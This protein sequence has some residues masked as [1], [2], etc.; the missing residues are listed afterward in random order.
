MRFSMMAV[1]AN[2]MIDACKNFI[3]DSLECIE[4]MSGMGCPDGCIQEACRILINHAVNLYVCGLIGEEFLRMLLEGIIEDDSIGGLIA[5]AN[6]IRKDI[7]CHED[8]Q[9]IS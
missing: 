8:G 2:C 3:V 4:K 7:V 6:D 9:K 5:A 1:D